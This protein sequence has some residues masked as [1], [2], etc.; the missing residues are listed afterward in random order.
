MQA[1]LAGT[2]APFVS[3]CAFKQCIQT[4]LENC[5]LDVQVSVFDMQVL[6]GIA[7]PVDLS[8]REALVKAANT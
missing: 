6:E 5:E 2:A 4:V 7:I 3:C 8:D 1:V